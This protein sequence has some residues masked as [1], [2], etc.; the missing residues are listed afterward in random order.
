MQCPVCGG[1]AAERKSKP[2][3]GLAADCPT[4]GSV[5]VARTALRRFGRLD[6]EA[7]ERAYDCA[8]VFAPHR[9]GEIIIT[10]MDF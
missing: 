2:V 10:T 1:P 3:D 4:H 5:A 6:R 9:A 7:R 8:K